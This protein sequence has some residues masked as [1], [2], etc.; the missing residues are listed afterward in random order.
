MFWKK[1]EAPREETIRPCEVD[2]MRCLF[3]RFVNEDKALLK[4]NAYLLPHEQREIV[5]E[6]KVAGVVPRCCSTEVVRTTFALVEYPDGSLGKVD[7]VKVCFTDK[8]C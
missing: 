1:K 4:I 3:H 7:P 2:G 6:F 5:A 8:G